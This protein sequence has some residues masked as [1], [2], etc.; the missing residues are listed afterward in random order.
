MEQSAIQIVRGDVHCYNYIALNL[1]H[2]SE[3]SQQ[4]PTNHAS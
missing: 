2:D 1:E 4:F 3:I